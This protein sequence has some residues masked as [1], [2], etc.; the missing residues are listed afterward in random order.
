MADQYSPIPPPTPPWKGVGPDAWWNPLSPSWPTTRAVRAA[1]EAARR[2]MVKRGEEMQ[3]RIDATQNAASGIIPDPIQ[4]A[5]AFL[6]EPSWGYYV[7]TVGLGLLSVA[8]IVGGAA[9][10]HAKNKKRRT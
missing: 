4:V 1:A 5:V 7:P 6:D 8:A 9:L 10:Y 2:E 3:A